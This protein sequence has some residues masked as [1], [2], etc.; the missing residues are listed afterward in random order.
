MQVKINSLDRQIEKKDLE[1][2]TRKLYIYRQKDRPKD[3]GGNGMRD[4]MIK[5]TKEDFEAYA[6]IQRSGAID[7]SNITLVSKLS[8]LSKDKVRNITNRYREVSRRF[9]FIKD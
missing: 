1:G 8:G 7:M 5:I 3:E 4:E 2:F 6:R 9:K